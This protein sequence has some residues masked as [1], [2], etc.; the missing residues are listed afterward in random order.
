MNTEHISPTFRFFF[1]KRIFSILLLVL[2]VL[3]GVIAYRSMVKESDPDL[4]IP[5]ATV[6]TVWPGSPPELVE[7]QISTGIEKKIKSLSRVKR[8]FSS[9]RNSI[10]AIVVEFDAD[11]SL[12]ESMQLL[13]TKV[14]EAENEFPD[15]VETPE[16]EEIAVSEF[17]VLTFIFYGDLDDVQMDKQAQRLKNQLEIISGVKKAEVSGNREEI[18]NVQLLPSRLADLRI[19][20]LLVK[21]RIIEANIDM[22]WGK[23]EEPNLHSLLELQGRFRD[24]EVLKALPILRLAQGRVVR[25]K[26]IALVQFDLEEEK[27]RTSMS[28][29]GEEYEKAVSIDVYKSPGADT[30]KVIQQARA[31]MEEAER[32]VDW[33]IALEY[34]VITDMSEQIWD[35]LG[36]AFNNVWQAMLGV[37]IIL[38]VLLSWRE[39]LIA[40][41]SIPLTFFGALAVLSSIG[42]TLNTLVVFGMVLALGL[43][44]DDFIL[45]MEGMHDGLSRGLSLEQAQ[46]FTIKTYA[47]PSLSGTLTTIL[48]MAPLLAIGGISGKFIRVIPITTITCL[49]LSYLISI[50][51]DIPLSAFLIRQRGSG[52]KK[53]SRVDRITEHISNRLADWLQRYTVRNNI[54]AGLWCLGTVVLFVVSLMG[55]GMI[56]QEMF[57]KFEATRNLGISVELTPDVDLDQAQR[58]ADRLGEILRP[59]P[60]FENIT[61]YIGMKSPFSTVSLYDSLL[62]TEAPYLLG[63]SCLFVVKEEREKLAY[64]YAEDLRDELKAVLEQVPGATITLAAQDGGASGDD[65]IQIEI[66]GSDMDILRRISTD[67]QGELARIPGAMNVRDTLGPVQ[68]SLRFA[69]RHEVLDFYGI[70]EAS[71][72]EQVR[73]A[74]SSDEIGEFVMPGTEDNLDIML[75]MAWPSRQGAIGGPRR[76]EELYQINVFNDRGESVAGHS[77]VQQ[78]LE[79]ASLSIAHKNGRRAVTVMSKTFGRTASEVLQDLLPRLN[80]M[81]ENWP[82]GY[83]YRVGGEVENMEETFGSSGKALVVAFVLVFSILAL[84]FDSFRQPMIIMF[85]V[86]FALIGVFAG[87]FL[88]WLPMSFMAFVGLISLVGIAVNDAIVLIETMNAHRRNGLSVTEAAARGAGDRLRPIFSTTLTTT[89]GLTP[90]ALSN[91]MWMPLC[92][93]IIFGLIASTIICLFVIPCLYLLLTPNT[94][95]A[96]AE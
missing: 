43:L 26:D 93:A 64:E 75:G 6:V 94:E 41:L 4:E 36:E 73:I 83:S 65:P 67:I 14:N 54:V 48:A 3:S 61:K 17:P 79:Q 16:I 55:F 1:I 8:Y 37:F 18:V 92:M 30:I 56:P 46:R 40:G 60:Y 81:Q 15:G 23:F 29:E 96:P 72:A 20:P 90:L 86:P 38:L 35:S 74:T 71:M 33:P 80:D 87:F 31:M 50:F 68:F 82:N 21:N 52:G 2:L 57:P 62:E 25:L 76:W 34:R 88:A 89:V 70:S 69:P 91:P 47:I 49:A 5:M 78:Q 19:S 58:V 24:I 77:L 45:V 13:R 44:V 9:S 85:S 28:V 95:I 66:F 63:F 39:A 42:Y 27:V 12:E 32:S 84:L 10:S 53:L 51:I 7:K 11:A 22:P 59:K